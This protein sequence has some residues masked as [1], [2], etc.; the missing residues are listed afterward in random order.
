MKQVQLDLPYVEPVSDISR[1]HARLENGIVK[2]EVKDEMEQ[3]ELLNRAA[4][5]ESRGNTWE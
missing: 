2:P 5:Q 4:D 3:F 1:F